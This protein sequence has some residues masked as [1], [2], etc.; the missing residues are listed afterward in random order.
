[1]VLNHFAEESQIQTYDLVRGSHKNFAT[2]QLTCFVLLHKRSLL[3]KILEVLLKDTVY[4]KESF[5]AKN[6][7]RSPY[8]V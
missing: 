3:H 6:Q 8:R 4:R 2:S 7:T 5:P 1:V